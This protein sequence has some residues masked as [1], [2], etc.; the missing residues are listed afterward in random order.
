MERFN[1][2]PFR[3]ARARG[4]RHASFQPNSCMQ[5]H[6]ASWPAL[7]QAIDRIYD[8]HVFATRAIPAALQALW[9]VWLIRPRLVLIVE[10]RV[11][12]VRTVKD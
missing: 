6:G 2:V 12:K 11:I 10:P 1:I 4:M 8:R 3:S 9:S 5:G 7:M